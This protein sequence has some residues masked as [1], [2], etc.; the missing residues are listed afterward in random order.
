MSQERVTCVLRWVN[1]RTACAWEPASHLPDRRKLRLTMV[2]IRENASLPV[3]AFDQALSP[4]ESGYFVARSWLSFLPATTASHSDP[5]I[6]RQPTAT[7]RLRSC[8]FPDL[9]PLRASVAAAHQPAAG[10][11]PLC[12]SNGCSCGPNGFLSSITLHVA[13][14]PRAAATIVPLSDLAHHDRLHVDVKQSY[15]LCPFCLQAGQ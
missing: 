11:C 15:L 12:L 8:R 4:A 2:A 6:G 13:R 10:R 9:N 1:R 7:N 14:S 3:R 5:V